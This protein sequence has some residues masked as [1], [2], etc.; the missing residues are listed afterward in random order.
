MFLL[1]CCCHFGFSQKDSSHAIHIGSDFVVAPILHF[2]NSGTFNFAPG[3]LFHI[4]SH[5][6]IALKTGILYH[7]KPYTVIKDKIWL[8][9]DTKTTFNYFQLWV[10][11][12][13][14]LI[15]GKK[16]QLFI[17]LGTLSGK[18][19]YKEGIEYNY[20]IDYMNHSNRSLEM[21]VG[22]KYWPLKKFSLNI[23]PCFIWFVNEVP[24]EYGGP[25]CYGCGYNDLTILNGTNSRA[26]LFIMI[27][28][29]YDYIKIKTK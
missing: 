26:S 10:K 14:A 29:S 19:I 24:S 2:S 3:F 15:E 20:P 5:N 16:S 7:L 11:F 8:P 18:G 12:D 27:S 1:F 6:V 25:V 28:V 21:G 4:N 23:E 13:V 9:G 17:S 22:Y